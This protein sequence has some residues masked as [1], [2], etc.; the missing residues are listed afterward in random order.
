[1][2][3]LLLRLFLDMKSLDGVMLPARI[4]M[5]HLFALAIDCWF[6][7]FRGVRLFSVAWLRGLQFVA[8]WLCWWSRRPAL[9][10]EGEILA[11]NTRQDLLL[12]LNVFLPAI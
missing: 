6:E 7:S 1:M 3:N 2:S 9:R 5:N 10:S 4:A 11:L 12:N 8:S